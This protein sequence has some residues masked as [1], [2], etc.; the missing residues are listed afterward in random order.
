MGLPGR[1]RLP[2]TSEVRR[3]GPSDYFRDVEVRL[4]SICEHVRFLPGIQVEDV[5]I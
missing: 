1:P 5:V 3:T 4:G 2:E